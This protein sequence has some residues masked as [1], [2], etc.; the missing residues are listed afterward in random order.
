MK[1]LIVGA[2]NVGGTLGRRWAQMGHTVI[3]GTRDPAAAKIQELVQ[4]SGSNSSATADLPTAAKA[5]ELIL[6][7]TP[8]NATEATLTTLGDLTGKIVV[9]ATNPIGPG[10]RLETPAAGSGAAAVQSWA[11]G[12]QV[13]K[14]FN[15][16]GFNNMAEPHYTGESTTMFI[17]GDDAAAKQIVRQL[18]EELGFDVA[19]VGGLNTAHYLE[20][21]AMVWINLAMV[22]GMGR[23]IALKL[24]RREA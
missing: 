11:S 24:V 16:T 19:D 4:A 14:A 10:F 13:V 20:A 18:T 21:L 12:A 23:D 7:A 17:C 22:Q 2:G 1:I 8:W 15:T 5:A 3:F 9:D 6:V